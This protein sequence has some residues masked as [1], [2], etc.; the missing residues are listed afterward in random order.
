MMRSR[1][2]S[3]MRANSS[4]S[5]ARLSER[6]RRARRTRG[7]RDGA[8]RRRRSRRGDRSAGRRGRATSSGQLRPQ[9]ERGAAQHEPAV[10][11]REVAARVLGERDEVGVRPVVG[12][13]VVG[14]PH[15]PVGAELARRGGRRCSHASPLRLG[16]LEQVRRDLEVQVGVLDE[17]EELAAA[18]GRADRRRGRR[19][20][21]GRARPVA[22][23]TARARAA[24]AGGAR[25][26]SATTTRR[27]S[28]GAHL[29]HART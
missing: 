5:R 7:R 19:S 11:R 13:R 14:A 18:G 25:G 8:R 26:G 27:P 17:S 15:Q 6:R 10:V 21:S 22:R 20:R 3:S 23:G 24:A 9:P 12:L 28:V 29:P 4:G 2:A 16:R 1:S